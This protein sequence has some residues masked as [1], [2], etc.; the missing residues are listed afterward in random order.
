MDEFVL[1]RITT[2]SHYCLKWNNFTKKDDERR[3]SQTIVHNDHE[4]AKV[5]NS[6]IQHSYLRNLELFCSSHDKTSQE[7]QMLS[8]SLF[9]L[10]LSKVSQ[11]CLKNVSK[12][13][14]KSLQ[15]LST[16]SQKSLKSLS[17]VSQKSLKSP[18]K[19]SQ[20]F[21]KSRSK[22]IQNLSKVSQKSLKS[23]SKVTQKSLKTL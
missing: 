8:R 4:I 11:K 6:F 3:W 22:V 20:K 17:K 5:E 1:K 9:C 21:L 14:S 18:S 19:V 13:S 16:V 10:C 23:L 15:S 2:W 7:L 12:V